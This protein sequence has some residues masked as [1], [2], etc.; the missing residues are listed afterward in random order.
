MHLG[1]CTEI[2]PFFNY[3]KPPLILLYISKYF[4][5]HRVSYHA[6]KT[7]AGVGQMI[8]DGE[9]VSGLRRLKPE[10]S[11][12]MLTLGEGIGKFQWT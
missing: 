7:V 12:Y 8:E 1:H 3:M 11:L 9:N 10:H 5:H 4:L 6:N 2:F